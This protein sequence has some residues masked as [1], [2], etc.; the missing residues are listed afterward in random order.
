MAR[1]DHHFVMT[2]QKAQVSARPVLLCNGSRGAF[3]GESANIH[4]PFGGELVSC[5]TSSET[6]GKENAWSVA[7]DQYQGMVCVIGHLAAK[8]CREFICIKSGTYIAIFQSYNPGVQFGFV[9][10][11]QIFRQVRIAP[12]PSAPDTRASSERLSGAAAG[13]P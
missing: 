7:S 2:V 5:K 9:S 13:P 8:P 10:V 4:L 3:C 6:S 12:Q 1:R 11:K